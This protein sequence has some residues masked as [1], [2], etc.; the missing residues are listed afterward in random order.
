[1]KLA[2]QLAYRNLMGAGLKTWLNV[3]ILAFTYILI[4]F[5]NGFMNGWNRQAVN[6]A[7]EW[8]YGQGQFWHED[9]DPIDPFTILD[10]HGIIPEIDNN[11]VVPVLV[12]QGTIYP[13]GRMVSMLI[14]GI[15]ANQDI[16]DL[17]T[18]LLSSNGNELSAIIGKKFANSNKLKEGDEVLVRWRDKNGTFDAKNITVKGIFDTDVVN[19]DAGQ[20][21]IDLDKLYSM[22][23]LDNRA[24]FMI[25]SPEYR[26]K[27]EIANW[28]WHS[29][30]ELLSGLYSIIESK[31]FGGSIMYIL[32]LSIALL[33]IF[34]TQVLSIFRRQKEI[35]T[36]VALGMTRQQVVKLFTVEGA[37]YSVMAS[38]VAFLIGLPLLWMVAKN[39]IPIPEASRNA[40]VN[41]SAII[42]PY[43]GL[44]LILITLILVV[45][46][47]T[48]VS[49]MPARK[50]A[51]MDPVNALK[52]KLQ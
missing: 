2:F 5:Y 18:G 12:R 27:T 48:I 15:P 42:Y 35:G 39:G 36:Y 25:A 29:K 3:G 33:A 22:T 26:G 17:P 51:K 16:L 28:S 46:A 6:D 44:G 4:V 38:I 7:V 14:K 45:L 10:G 11:E 30:D 52:G 9:Y 43:F 50:I 24:S 32:L 23:G 1:M 21:W 34:D 8:E 20:I 47:A 49:Y 41:M 31:R 37:M 19:V 13:D 40:G